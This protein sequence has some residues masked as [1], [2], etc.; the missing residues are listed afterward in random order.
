MLYSIYSVWVNV[1]MCYLHSQA[2]PKCFV[3]KRREIPFQFTIFGISQQTA[4]L[5]LPKKG[6]RGIEEPVSEATKLLP[7]WP[8]PLHIRVSLSL[9]KFNH[10]PAIKRE[11]ENEV[12]EAS[13]H[14]AAPLLWVQ[15]FSG[16]NMWLGI[17]KILV[18]N[19][20]D[21][22]CH[23]LNLLSHTVTSTCKN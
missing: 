20:W 3:V 9:V 6:G 15:W 23:K 19:P 2:H 14:D 5:L 18:S 21:T 13:P 17:Q 7:K 16:K 12:A 11:R 10:G 1:L 8:G 22:H 4:R